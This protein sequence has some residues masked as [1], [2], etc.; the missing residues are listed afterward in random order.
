MTH[1]FY[2][3]AAACMIVFD[4]SRYSTL[5]EAVKWKND[6][7]MKVN[8]NETNQKPCILI[9]NKVNIRK[10]SKLFDRL[11]FFSVIYQKMVNFKKKHMYQTFVNIINLLIISKH[12]RK[13]T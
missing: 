8:Y 2:R 7:D 3:D 9:G 5:N 6:F 4:V 12:R 13:R 1:L 10:I 11:S